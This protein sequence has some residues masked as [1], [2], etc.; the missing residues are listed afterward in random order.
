VR[1]ATRQ[2]ETEA[3]DLSKS[4]KKPSSPKAACGDLERDRG[5]QPRLKPPRPENKYI[6]SSESHL[7]REP[8][9]HIRAAAGLK[10]KNL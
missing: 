9:P 7:G 5:R 10:E 3:Q 8:T 1:T 2:N 4:I 6:T